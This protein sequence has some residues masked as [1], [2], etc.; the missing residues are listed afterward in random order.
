LCDGIYLSVYGASPAIWDYAVSTAKAQLVLEV[1]IV[2]N[3]CVTNF[4][5]FIFVFILRY[6]VLFA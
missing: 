3:W 2:I 4:L 5:D 6:F 1:L